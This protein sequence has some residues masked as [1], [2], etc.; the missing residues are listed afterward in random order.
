LKEKFEDI[1][2]EN[3]EGDVII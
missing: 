2:L 1:H 3:G